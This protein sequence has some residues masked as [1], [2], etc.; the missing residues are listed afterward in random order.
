MLKG[1]VLDWLRRARNKSRLHFTLIDPDK[2]V[3][4]GIETAAAMARAANEA[5]SDAIL[6]GGSLGVYE[7]DLGTVIKAI[8]EAAPGKPVIL[9]PGSI[10]G[11]SREADAV[12]FLYL[13]NSV[14]SY[15][16]TWAQTQA[17]PVIARMRLEPIPTAYIIVGYGGAA[18]YMGHVTPVPW[19]KPELAAAHALAGAMMG[20]QLLYLEAGS[21]A[22]RPV[23]DEAV[24]ITR[25][26]LSTTGLDPLVIVGGGV[27]SGSEACRKARA[28]A[29]ILVT[30][31][32][33]EEDPGKLA[34][35][36]EA[37]KSCSGQG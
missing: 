10:A 37:F 35:I 22:P 21:G 32:I 31:T 33:A 9:F 19:D 23:P 24:S 16:S 36:V 20:A 4:E 15:M 5:G 7:P 6:V 13:M 34:E 27:R 28:G 26:L 11:L 18:G 17:A 14:N 30:G 1:R 3:D 8:R 29:D 25:R 2:V 12:L